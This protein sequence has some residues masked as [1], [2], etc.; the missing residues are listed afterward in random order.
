M[1]NE[2]KNRNKTKLALLIL[3]LV[4]LIGGAYVL[5]NKLGKEKM[6]IRDRH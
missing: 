3:L 4:L 1:E 6:C 2:N 5:Y